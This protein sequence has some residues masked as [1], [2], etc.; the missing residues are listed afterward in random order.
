[1]RKLAEL[2]EARKSTGTPANLAN[3]ANRD[4]TGQEI[5]NF[6]NFRKGPTPNSAFTP[7]LQ[8]RIEAMAHRWAYKPE[9]LHDVLQRARANPSGWWVAVACDEEREA[10]FRSSGVLPADAA[11]GSRR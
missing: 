4:V 11:G 10:E 6:R 8:R 5:R 7:E 2:L 9:E 1:M 3:P